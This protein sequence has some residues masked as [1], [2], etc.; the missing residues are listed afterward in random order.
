MH[1]NLSLIAKWDF[2]ASLRCANVKVADVSVKITRAGI[3]DYII[4]DEIKGVRGGAL[5]DTHILLADEIETRY[6]FITN[7]MVVPIVFGTERAY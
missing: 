7:C 6:D 4:H 3:A 5:G 2:A 1:S